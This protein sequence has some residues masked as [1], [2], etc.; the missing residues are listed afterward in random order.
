MPRVSCGCISSGWNDSQGQSISDVPLY[1]TTSSYQPG[2]R[3]TLLC[4]DDFKPRLD[5]WVDL[6]YSNSYTGKPTKIVYYGAAVDKTPQGC[7]QNNSGSTSRHE[8]GG[9][10]DLVGLDFSSRSYWWNDNYGNDKQFTMGVEA[11]CHRKFKYSLGHHYN[12]AHHDHIHMDDSYD[13]AYGSTSWAMNNFLLNS[14]NDIFGYSFNTAKQSSGH[15]YYSTAV[16][17]AVNSVLTSYGGVSNPNILAYP[18]HW[19]AYCRTAW[20]HGTD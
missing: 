16:R 14:L 3:S 20:L 13:V 18:L 17:N 5:N 2:S 4:C 9:A 12:S 6:W 11:S 19:E 10:F 15:N 8:N 7:N 1:Y